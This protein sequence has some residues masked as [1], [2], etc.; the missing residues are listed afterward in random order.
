MSISTIIS[1]E[2]KLF[3]LFVHDEQNDV[4]SIINKKYKFHTCGN[5]SYY[6]LEF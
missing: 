6:A 5:E 4:L 1:A 2:I 3:F